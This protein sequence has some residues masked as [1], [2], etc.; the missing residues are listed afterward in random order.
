MSQK[1]VGPIT[2]NQNARNYL[3][4][5]KIP[6][7]FDSL[8]AALIMEKPEDH[9]DFLNTTLEQIRIHGVQ[10]VNWDTFVHHLHPLRNSA[11]RKILGQKPERPKA[12]P[13]PMPLLKDRAATLYQPELFK[14]TET[15]DR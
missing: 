2:A 11:R 7:M 5:F 8:V 15:E 9:Y 1:S 14:L 12:R 3:E 10:N 6:Q 13:P 4:E